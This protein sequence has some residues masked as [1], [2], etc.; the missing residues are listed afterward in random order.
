MREQFGQPQKPDIAIITSQ[1]SQYSVLNRYANLA[2]QRAVRALAYGSRLSAYMV[3]E[4]QLSSLGTPKLAILPSPQALT[5]AG[6][7]R[8]MDYVRS[9]G[10]LLITGPVGRDEHWR[11]TDYTKELG[12]DAEVLPLTFSE[13]TIDA[14]N[15]R[16]E[17]HYDLQAQNL[18]EWMR[19]SDGKTF[20]DVSAGAGHIFWA[21]S[22][23][24]LS[25]DLDSIAALYTA[26]ATK[27]KVK[28][29]FTTKNAIP[30]GVLIYPQEFADHTLYIISSETDAAEDIS[31]RDNASGK[32]IN[33]RL[34]P[35]RAALIFV[36]KADGKILGSYGTTSEASAATKAR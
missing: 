7:R 21:S 9:G 19:F 11:R 2:Q 12:I 32:E 30:S 16:P 8:L 6:W 1:A 18:L 27:A 26:V 29:V 20:H 25:E 31:L 14:G 5:S 10:N 17:F 33:L 15:S 3:T 28:N 35:Q 22:P 36:R 24:E 13:Q 34:A 4:N 23:V